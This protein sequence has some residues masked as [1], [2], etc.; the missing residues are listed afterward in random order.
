MRLTRATRTLIS[1]AFACAALVAACSDAGPEVIPPQVDTPATTPEGHEE[2]PSID[3]GLPNYAANGNGVIADLRADTN[4]DGV[5]RFDNSADDDGEDV[6]DA[7][8]GAVFL[9]N[10][11]D[12]QVSCSP[13]IDDIEID[14]CNDAADQIVNGADDAL[15]LAR[16][17]TQPWPQAPASA[18]GKITF[19]AGSRVRLFKVQNGQ[20]SVLTSGD[21]LTLAEVKSGLELAI[22]GRDIVR[23]SNV[24]NGFVDL[25]LTVTAD[26]KTASDTVRMRVSPV[27][28]FHHGLANEAT[29]VSA[30]VAAGNVQMRADLAEAASIAG[31][32]PPRELF[33]SDSWAQDFFETAFMSM[34]AANGKQHVIR[35]NLRSANVFSPNNS[36]NPLRSAGRL[37]FGMRGKDMAAIQEYD[38]FHDQDSDTLNSFGNLE[39]I[40]PYSFAGKS[41]PMGR[42]LRGATATFAPDPLFQRMIEAQSVQPAVYVDTSWLLV[43]HVD[44]TMSFVK[45]NNAR[46][47][48][49]LVNDPTLARNMLVAQSNAGNG[50]VPM[51]VGKYW[52]S[53]T[54]AQVT[55]DQVLSDQEVMSASAEAAT[56]VAGQVAK[57]KAETGL[58]DAE[59]VKIPFLHMPLRGYS[60]GYQ[61]G[62]VNGLYMTEK[63]FVSPDPHGP[64]IAGKDIF[65]TAM[66][67]A[68]APLAI[69]V[70]F[71]E[72]WDVYHR[73]SGEVH[74]GTNSTRRIPDAKWWESGR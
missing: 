69:T 15:D 56:E 49:L 3:D 14:A 64:V 18:Q 41:Y 22:E 74:C 32:A 20:Y 44:E 33:T 65:K 47:W 7:T 71:A 17:K 5:I 48:V 58:T 2:P 6:W 34:P 29:W 12:D 4:R 23:D 25:T 37:V 62:L 68:L 66:Q 39:T 70:H 57:L 31:V 21:R 43:G 63:H 19:T 8:H 59:I 10:I 72:D 45:A 36:R 11:D 42:V 30:L 28:T 24:W 52:G 16:L 54:P 9:A 35:V 40:P 61:P 67:Q 46:G 73:N 50:N 1:A 51:F 27:M 55:I 53:S 26:N 38:R 60:I 13:N